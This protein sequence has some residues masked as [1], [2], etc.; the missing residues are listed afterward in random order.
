[1]F[2]LGGREM[3]T[4]CPIFQTFE[5]A[6]R[7]SIELDQLLGD[8]VARLRNAEPQLFKDADDYKWDD[9]VSE[10]ELSWVQLGGALTIPVAVKEKGSKGK[11]KARHL[12]IRFDLYRDIADN[13]LPASKPASEALIVIG[14][15]PL[16]DSPWGNDLMVVTQDR[17]LHN[18]EAWEA[19]RNNRHADGRLLEWARAAQGKN[20][21][22]RGWIFALPLRSFKDP[23][24]VEKQLIQP[25]VRLLARNEA[26]DVSLA[27]TDA[28]KWNQ[29]STRTP[30]LI[31]AS[32]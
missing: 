19:C 25:I 23:E 21:A 8:I 1:M 2:L 29:Q 16:R 24:S 20:W 10:E 15:S 32:T 6:K 5:A 4:A 28:I 30:S 9:C 26:P 13:E 27:G 17:S 11:P 12:S 31:G 7:V 14:Y 18:Q 22:E 3:M